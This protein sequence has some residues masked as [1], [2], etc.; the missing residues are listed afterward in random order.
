MFL[1]MG[2]YPNRQKMKTAIISFPVHEHQNK[3]VSV[4][5][6][7]IM[8]VLSL[9]FIYLCVQRAKQSCLRG[10]L[11]V[12]TMIKYSCCKRKVSGLRSVLRKNIAVSIYLLR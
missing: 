6:P 12:S 9:S 11:T 10:Y 3:D 2:K 5:G 7:E 1:E 4:P 8:A